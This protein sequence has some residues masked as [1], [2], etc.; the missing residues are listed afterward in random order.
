[1]A[2]LSAGILLYRHRGDGIEVL[3]V[4]PGGPYWRHRDAGAWQIPKG[5]VDPGEDYAACALREF[6]EEL[7]SRPAG[8]PR[9]LLRIRQAGGKSVEAFAL[10]GHLDAD[11]IVSNCFE[12]EWPPRSGQRQSFPE[13][14]RAAWF[15]LAEARARMLPSQLPLLDALEAELG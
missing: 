4:L 10:E 14:E 2:A 9:P 13:V 3:L 11:R 15:P 7:G 1:M 5:G 12:M 8:T 6:E